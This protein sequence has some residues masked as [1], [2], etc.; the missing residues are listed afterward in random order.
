MILTSF[1]NAIVNLEVTLVDE[2][3][4]NRLTQLYFLERCKFIRATY[5][6]AIFLSSVFIHVISMLAVRHKISF[7]IIQISKEKTVLEIPCVKN[8]LRV[9]F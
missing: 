4:C 2:C 7:V 9:V 8:L 5:V 6:C 1:K 3:Q